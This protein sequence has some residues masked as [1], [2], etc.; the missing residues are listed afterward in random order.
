MSLCKCNRK[1]KYRVIGL[2]DLY[3]LKVLGIREG[4]L[5]E[6]Q[7]RQPLGGPMVVK[8]GNRSI[9]IAKDVAR[10]IIVREVA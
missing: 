6:V 3:L 2:P 5:F 4:T 8:V 1:N 7:S 9:A 10:E